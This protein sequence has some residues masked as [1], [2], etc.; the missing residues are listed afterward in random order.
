MYT[1]IETEIYSRLSHQANLQREI[2]VQ[3]DAGYKY[4]QITSQFSTILKYN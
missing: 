4:Y 2:S 3:C 1:H